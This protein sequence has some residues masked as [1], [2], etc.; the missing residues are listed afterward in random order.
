MSR[1]RAAAAWWG[2]RTD[3]ARARANFV[4]RVTFEPNTGCHLWTGGVDKDG[5]GKFQVL[6]SYKHQAH[7]RA[8]RFAWEDMHGPL[9][10]GALL[11]HSCDQPACVNP[12]HLHPGTQKQNIA[13][14]LQR[15][16]KAVGE[17]HPWTRHS[18]A[19]ILEIRRLRREGVPV[20][21]LAQRF[22]MHHSNIW[23]IEH[24]KQR[25]HG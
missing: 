25:R 4:R 19:T 13:E 9:P 15:H 14:A 3:R 11:L 17:A 1:A 21:E 7:V 23:A 16:R 6:I 5:Y 10:S 24:G 22:G 2:D 18:A 20:S 12:D 8:H